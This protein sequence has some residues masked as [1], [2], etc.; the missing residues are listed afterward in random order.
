MGE[1]KDCSMVRMEGLFSIEA[2]VYNMCLHAIT[3]GF[4]SVRGF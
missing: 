1:G 2:S 3:V 4:T